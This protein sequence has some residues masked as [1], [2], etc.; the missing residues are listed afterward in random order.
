MALSR[1]WE[2]VLWGGGE[3]IWEGR[4]GEARSSVS[5][6]VPFRGARAPRLSVRLGIVR[7]GGQLGF[8]AASVLPEKGPSGLG[9][10]VPP[11]GDGVGAQIEPINGVKAKK[12][13]RDLVCLSVGTEIRSPALPFSELEGVCHLPVSLF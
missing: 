7:R 3:S 9:L 4:E 1:S 13:Q 10:C 5:G 6:H 12:E 8:W 2:A 11:A